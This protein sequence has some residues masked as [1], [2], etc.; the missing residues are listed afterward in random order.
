MTKS[1]LILC[2]GNSC[3]SQIAEYLW[4]EIGAGNWQ[5]HSA[6]SN[7]AGYV[8]PLAV[9][10]MRELGQDLA[11][12]ESKHVDRFV[13]ESI[14]LVVT[15]C[16]SAKETCPALPGVKETLHWPFNDPA[17]ATGTDDEKLVVFREV[18]DQIRKQIAD[19]LGV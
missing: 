1:V 9:E 13:G 16:D 7:P 8:H 6:G 4:N 3:R 15:V 11:G 17:E 14:D 5:A 18:R 10:A 19:Y 2:T 12:A